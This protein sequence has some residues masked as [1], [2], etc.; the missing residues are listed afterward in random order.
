MPESVVGHK[1]RAARHPTF[2]RI[3]CLSPI[4]QPMASEESGM[5]LENDEANPCFG[6]GPRN[7]RGLRLS[8]HRVGD[9][10]ETMLLADVTME[11]WPGRLH[12][13]IL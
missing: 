8:F 7:P 6:C 2:I 1:V 11:G 13:G 10:V 9:R 5:A 3:F 12:S 4:G